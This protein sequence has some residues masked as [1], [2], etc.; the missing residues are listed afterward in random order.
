MPKFKV[1]HLTSVHPRYDTRIFIKM[2]ISLSTHYD[3]TLV[4]ADGKGD[5]VNQNVTICDVG[6]RTGGRISRM[7]NTVSKVFKKAKQLDADIYHLHDPELIPIGLKLKKLGKKVIFD[8]H[9]DL[10]LQVL[11][12]TYM[13]KYLTRIVSKA[14]AWYEQFACSRLD[15]V[16]TATPYIRNKFLKINPN[17]VDINNFPKLEE[18]SQ[19]DTS[20]FNNRKH[21]CYIGGITKVRGIE[22][23]IQAIEECDNNIKL[24]LAGNFMDSELEIKMKSSAGWSHVVDRGWLDRNGIQSVL[25]SSFTGL[26]TLHPIPNYQ[27]SLPVKMFEYMAAGLPVIYSNISLWKDII[28]EENCGISVDPYSPTEIYK[29]IEYLYQNLSE[30]KKMGQKGRQAVIEKFNWTIEENKL[31]NLYNTLLTG[32]GYK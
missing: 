22:E 31:I 24:E 12:K 17:S 7:T 11:S 29:A 32:N 2:C 20:N 23:I 4:V 18:L 25:R 26:V 15:A 5:E 3:T 13:N 8:A 21:C 14:A 6:F 27:D 1:V 16:I 30:A 9:E 10:P 28:E 19:L